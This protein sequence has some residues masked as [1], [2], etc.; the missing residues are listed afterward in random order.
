MES[1]IAVEKDL[2][3]TIPAAITNLQNHGIQ[4]KD[5][6]R[7]NNRDVLE[8]LKTTDFHRI[9]NEFDDQM[10]FQAQFYRNYMSMFGTLLLVIRASR[11]QC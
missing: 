4:K 6:L 1:N 3:K 5:K 2:R 10:K 9:Q 11:Q 8:V 7:R